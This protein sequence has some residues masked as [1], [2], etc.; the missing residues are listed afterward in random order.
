MCPDEGAHRV[1]PPPNKLLF[2][3]FL[4]KNQLAISA[5]NIRNWLPLTVQFG[6]P[7]VI[8]QV[9]H[10]YRGQLLAVFDDDHTFSEIEHDVCPFCLSASPREPFPSSLPIRELARM[11]EPPDRAAR[12]LAGSPHHSAEHDLIDIPRGGSF[13][14]AIDALCITRATLLGELRDLGLAIASLL[15]ILCA[16]WRGILL[17]RFLDRLHLIVGAACWMTVEHSS[18]FLLE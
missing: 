8:T 4:R 10:P 16:V 9:F 3:L 13:G 7:L 18:A 12:L 2:V 1:R 14:I 6:L 11:R 5:P 17:R 15:L